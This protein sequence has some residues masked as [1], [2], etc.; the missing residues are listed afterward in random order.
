M[1]ALVTP[2]PDS[3]EDKLIGRSSQV[4]FLAEDVNARFNEWSKRGIRF[5][6]A[7]QTPGWGRRVCKL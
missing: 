2:Q 1:L 4:I 7:P 6:H 5:Q 3:E